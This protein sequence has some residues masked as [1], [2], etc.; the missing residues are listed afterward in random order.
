MRPWI[1]FKVVLMEMWWNSYSTIIYE[2]YKI[3][4]KITIKEYKVI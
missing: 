3:K 2:N 1:N 4:Y